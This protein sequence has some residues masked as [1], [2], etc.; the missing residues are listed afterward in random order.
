MSRNRYYIIYAAHSFL[1]SPLIYAFFDQTSIRFNLVYF[2]IISGALGLV[3]VR[4]ISGENFQIPKEI[5]AFWLLFLSQSFISSIFTT[6]SVPI[7]AIGL[8]ITLSALIYFSF[9]AAVKISFRKWI[10]IILFL[11]SIIFSLISLAM[12]VGV[13]PVPA[14]QSNLFAWTFGHN[15]LAGLLAILLPPSIVLVSGLSGVPFNRWGLAILI[16]FMTLLLSSGRAAIS[17]FLLGLVY[18]SRFGPLELKKWLKLAAIITLN[19]NIGI[20]DNSDD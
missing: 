7:S 18:L 3:L 11:S 9:G 5:K 14:N 2:L 6:N 16:P 12:A 8:S 1:L 15:R 17:G 13:I 19:S 10:P 4:K 20:I